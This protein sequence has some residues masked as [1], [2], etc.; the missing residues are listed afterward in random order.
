MANQVH[1]PEGMIFAN[2]YRIVKLIGSGGMANVYLGIDMNT[3]VNVAIK[4]LKPEFSSDEEFIRRFDAEAKSVASLNHANIVKVFGV[5]HEGNFRFIVQEY[6]EGITVKDLI[7][8]NGHLDWRNAV[9][10]VIQIGLALDYA[11]QNGIVH[12]DIKPQNILISRD[13]VAKITDFGIARAASSTTITMTGVQ[14]G[15]VHYFSPEQARGGNVGPQSDVYSLGVSLFEMVTGRLPFDGDSNVAIA[16]K[17]LQETPPVPSSLMQGIPKGL[18]SII[19]KCMQKSPERRYQTMRQLVTELDSLLVDPNGVYGVIS[20]V[21]EKTTNSDTNISFRQDPEYEKI[22]EI[23]KSAES[24][25]ISRFRDNVLLA[26]IVVVIIGVLIGIGILVVRA[27][28]NATQI[29]ENTDYEVENYIGLTAD[30]V[31]KKLEAAQVNY[32]VKYEITDAY[33]AGIVIDQSIAQGVV[34]SANS[35]LTNLVITVSSADETVVLQDYANVDYQNCFTSLKN[36]GLVPVLRPEPSDSVGPGLVIRTEP[37]AGT[38]LLR[39]ETVVIIYAIE[40]TSSIVPDVVGNNVTDAAQKLEEN[41]LNYTVEGSPEVL[42]LPANQQVVILTNPV[43]G[44]TVARKSTVKL[45]VGTR[46]DYQNGGT[47]TPTPPQAVVTV[48]VSGSGTATGGGTYELNTQVTLTATPASGFVFEC[49]LD[50][51]GNTLAISNTYTFTVKESTSFTAVFAPLPSATPV[52]TNTP[53]PVPT[54][55]PVPTPTEAPKPNPDQGGGPGGG[56]GPV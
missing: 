34:I 25:R 21:P 4:I 5:G 3:G 17:H 29:E 8:Q 28:G 31:I 18:D 13:R 55:T 1:G 37:E 36:L 40:P 51:Y 52:P 38:Q 41:N 12:R 48:N 20:N 56:P 24:R 19:A 2:K 16:V 39:G 46:E 27:V 47:P 6:I 35:K 7:N 11:H 9:P 23:E 32:S 33:E 49:W 14:M 50:Q 42:S 30:E 44:T 15:S 10:I 22:S 26:L 53:T 43:A 54:D 45:Y